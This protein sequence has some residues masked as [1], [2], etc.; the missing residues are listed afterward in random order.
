MASRS[1]TTPGNVICDGCISFCKQD[2]DAW[3]MERRHLGGE[4]SVSQGQE[5]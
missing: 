1:S 4:D 3:R 5:P 2:S